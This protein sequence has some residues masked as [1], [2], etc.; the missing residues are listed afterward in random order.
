MTKIDEF[1]SQILVI[2]S[3]WVA[4]LVIGLMAFYLIMTFLVFDI[5]YGVGT[6]SVSTPFGRFVQ[7]AALVVIL[8][9]M[10][11]I[12]TGQYT[13]RGTPYE[14][15]Y[16]EQ[17]YIAMKSDLQFWQE[18]EL[19]I[20]NDFVSTEIQAKPLVTTQLHYE[21][22]K[23]HPRSLVIRYDPRIEQGDIIQLSNSVRVYV[24][25][26]KRN[27]IRGNADPLVMNVEGW[28]TVL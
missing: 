6:V 1:H 11:S 4:K 3:S 18:R 25:S 9:I 24:D 17:Q 20:R 28:R 12:G 26:V 23:A 2:I 22:M 16:L 10:S 5:G 21:V 13:I 19:E 8:T 7:A 27:L 14:M 15:V